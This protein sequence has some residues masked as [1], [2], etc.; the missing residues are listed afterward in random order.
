MG[1]WPETSIRST[2]WTA[3]A[4]HRTTRARARPGR[5]PRSGP[6]SGRRARRGLRRRGGGR[7]PGGA[8]T[9][10]RTCPGT[11]RDCG[12][13][14]AACTPARTGALRSPLAWRPASG[15]P[16]TPCARARARP[17]RKEVRVRRG[18]VADEV[19]LQVVAAG[20]ARPGQGVV[21]EPPV[22]LRDAHHLAGADECVVE[23]EAFLC[24]QHPEQRS[25]RLPD[26]VDLLHPE[27]R[28]RGTR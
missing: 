1:R 3:P 25:P 24:S 16:G 27:A 26:E 12:R 20:G 8:G 21:V 22:G 4:A 13:V 10:P 14:P 9:A 6:G 15:H 11:P 5:G 28:A 18:T 17:R 2:P 7:C 23:V 19:P